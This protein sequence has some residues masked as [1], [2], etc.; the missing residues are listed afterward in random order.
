MKLYFSDIS[1]GSTRS[2]EGLACSWIDRDIGFWFWFGS[3]KFLWLRACPS[4][5]SSWSYSLKWSVELRFGRFMKSLSSSSLNSACPLSR[6][7]VAYSIAA[8]YST[9]STLTSSPYRSIWSSL[10]EWT[11]C[12]TRLISSNLC[13][14]SASVRHFSCLVVCLLCFFCDYS[15]VGLSC[16]SWFKIRALFSYGK[17][18]SRLPA[19]ESV[20][21]F[22]EMLPD[23]SC[24]TFIGKLTL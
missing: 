6:E 13:S 3:L 14:K 18:I 7:C 22:G 9:T 17:T 15:L 23:D 20:S 19:G 11:L 10:R 2:I 16:L 24:L 12:V 5:N 21:N 4:V 8:T 1:L